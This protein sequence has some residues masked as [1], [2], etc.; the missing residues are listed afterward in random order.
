MNTFSPSERPLHARK[1]VELGNGLKFKHL[2]A[3]LK[4]QLS[5]VQSWYFL[6]AQS[7][8]KAVMLLN[9]VNN[10]NKDFPIS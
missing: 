8:K 6:V 10:V 9:D 1:I 3:C 7:E 4:V 5:N 2:S